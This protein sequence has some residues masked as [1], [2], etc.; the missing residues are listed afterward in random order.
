MILTGRSNPGTLRLVVL[1]SWFAAKAIS[2][3]RNTAN[4]LLVRFC[5]DFSSCLS[6]LSSGGSKVAFVARV[7]VKN[8][9]QSDV[10]SLPVVKAAIEP[11]LSEFD[12]F[13]V[14]FHSVTVNRVLQRFRACQCI[15]GLQLVA[16]SMTPRQS[17]SI[18]EIDS[19]FCSG[20]RVQERFSTP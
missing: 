13:P 19:A 15:C 14:W 18:D 16:T 10:E 7:V 3:P 4:D 11:G 12:C 17:S 9:A 1:S 5:A 6:W 20:S 8:D 2:E